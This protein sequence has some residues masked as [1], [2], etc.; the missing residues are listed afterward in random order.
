MS[1][2]EYYHIY[3][4]SRGCLTSR[5]YWPS[6]FELAEQRKYARQL[7]QAEQDKKEE[8]EEKDGEE[9]CQA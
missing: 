9:K 5:G 2:P 8:S 4:F 6:D 1:G 3:G 7:E